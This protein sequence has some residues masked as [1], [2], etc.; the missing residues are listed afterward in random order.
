MTCADCGEVITDSESH[1]RSEIPDPKTGKW[2]YWHA[3]CYY[4]NRSESEGE[5]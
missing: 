2:V 4:D 3:R 5:A 1:I